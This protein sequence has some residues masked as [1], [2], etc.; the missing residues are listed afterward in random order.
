LQWPYAE[1]GADVVLAGHDHL[2]ERLEVKGLPYF[3]NGLGGMP[4]IYAFAEPPLPESRARYNE[5]WGAQL[6]EVYSNQ[7]VFSFITR[8]EKVIDV[9]GVLR[10]LGVDPRHPSLT[11]TPTLAYNDGQ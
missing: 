5:D 9:Y 8:A 7:M 11:L 3:V 2:Y 10:H 6:V 4:T 1:W